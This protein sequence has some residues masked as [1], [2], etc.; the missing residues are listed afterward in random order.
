MPK[1]KRTLRTIRYETDKTKR[2][3]VSSFKA[4]IKDEFF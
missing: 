4:A 2:Y 1:H 3:K